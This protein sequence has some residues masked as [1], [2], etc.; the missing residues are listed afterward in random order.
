MSLPSRTELETLATRAGAIALRHF[1][2][3]AAERKVDRTL[4][5]AAD[6]EVEAF[7]ATELGALVPEAA[8]VGEEGA[9]RAGRGELRIVIDPVDGTA[10][11]VAGLPT[12]CVCIGV[13]DGR[14]PVAGVVHLPCAG[15][16]YSAAGDEAW[17]NGDRL[18]PLRDEITGEQDAFI[19][20]HA[21]AHLRSRIIYRGKVRSLGSTAYHIALVARGVAQAALVGRA[22][23]WDLVA[24]G[25]VL[26][27]V[28]GSYAYRDG[29]P[30]DLSA[31]LD[32]R[33]APDDVVAGLP[34]VVERLRTLVTPLA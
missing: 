28:G 10:A 33:R 16:T 30:V 21:K 22:H 23:V 8:I 4:V 7:L 3:G 27:A 2:R 34:A 32:G 17:W 25:A 13:L 12:W 24:P 31:L 5:T 19:V 15:E 14:E 11:F 29:S 20:T 9:A 26:R 1:R 6:R 18:P